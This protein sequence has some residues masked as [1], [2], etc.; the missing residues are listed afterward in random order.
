VSIDRIRRHFAPKG[1]SRSL[2][3]QIQSSQGV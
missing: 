2:A 1:T 3:V